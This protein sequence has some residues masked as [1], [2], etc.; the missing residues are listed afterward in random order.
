MTAPN[1][2]R[3]NCG[4]SAL[5][6][7]LDDAGIDGRPKTLADAVAI[8]QLDV[9]GRL[10]EQ[11]SNTSPSTPAEAPAAEPGRIAEK[12]GRLDVEDWLALLLRYRG[13]ASKCSDISG[14]GRSTMYTRREFKDALETYKTV[15]VLL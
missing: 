8:A 14:V 7:I 6:E 13:N 1:P 4:V 12:A 10:A 2:S 3:G 5:A 11:V 15:S 9:L